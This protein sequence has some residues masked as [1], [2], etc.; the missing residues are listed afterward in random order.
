MGLRLGVLLLFLVLLGVLAALNTDF[1]TYPHTLY[2]GF[3]TYRNM[4]MGLLLLVLMLIPVL[5]FYFWAGLTRLR[6]E[7]DSARLLRDMEQ[8]RTSLDAQE[9]SRFAQLQ[10]HLDQ[11]L[12]ALEKSALETRALPPGNAN[13][14]A[15][16][17][18]LRQRVEALQ[19]DLGLQLAQMDDYLKRRLG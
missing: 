9:S 13:S 14:Q 8:L 5:V 19:D 10:S 2:L 7:A 4:P 11:R 16:L 17:T 12:S 15:E 1:L 18:A 3:A 6:A